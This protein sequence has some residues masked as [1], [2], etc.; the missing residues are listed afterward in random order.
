[1]ALRLIDSLF[2]FEW[3]NWD[4]CELYDHPSHYEVVVNVN[5]DPESVEVDFDNG[6]LRISGKRERKNKDDT[7]QS[8]VSFQ[9]TISIPGNVREKEISASLRG[10]ALRIT[11]PKTEPQSGQVKV[12]IKG[13][14]KSKL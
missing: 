14:P 4:G 1:M 9:D 12:T 7:Y 8:V 6:K 5:V 13:K 11:L 3:N 2:P 10:G